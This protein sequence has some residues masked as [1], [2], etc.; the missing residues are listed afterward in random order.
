GR[1]SP[2]A[3]RRRSG[4]GATGETPPAG[5]PARRA[6]AARAAPPSA[7]SPPPP[8][9]PPPARPTPPPPPPRAPRAGAAPPRSGGSRRA[10]RPPPAA[11]P[12]PPPPS[13]RSRRPTTAS[14]PERAPASRSPSSALALPCRHRDR[15]PARVSRREFVP[16]LDALLAVPPAPEHVA[17]LELPVEV[18]QPGL[19]PLEHAADLLELE[20]IAVD[21]ARH[22]VNAAPQRELLLRLAPLGP[23]PRRR[24]LVA[25]HQ[26][27]PLRVARHDVAHDTPHERQRA[28]RLGEREILARH[29]LLPRDHHARD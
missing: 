7:R 23:R 29:A 20:Q 8:P 14:T 2:R 6:R 21:L 24:E 13:W 5:R 22:R 4:A 27:A 28:V 26:L 19:E 3:W 15:P 17:P 25:M 11:W 9:P 16:V 10:A 1:A 18:H 12:P